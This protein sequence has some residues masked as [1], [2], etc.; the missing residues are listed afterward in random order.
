MESSSEP[1]LIQ[2]TETVYDALQDKFDF[3]SR[4]AVDIKGI[5]DM[6]VWALLG[7]KS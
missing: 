4:G 3:Q 6:Q 5:G 2:V 1:G 7:R